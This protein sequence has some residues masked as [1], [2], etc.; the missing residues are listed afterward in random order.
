MAHGPVMANGALPSPKLVIMTSYSTSGLSRPDAPAS[1]R[2]AAASRPP[3]ESRPTS[4]MLNVPS[5]F[6]PSMYPP[7]ADSVGWKW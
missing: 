5:S 4:S 7:N 2:N 6:C 3:G 1:A